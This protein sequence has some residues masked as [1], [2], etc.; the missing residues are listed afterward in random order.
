MSI[1]IAVQMSM[2]L[3]HS[4]DIFLTIYAKRPEITTQWRY[5]FFFQ[6]RP[7]KLLHLLVKKELMFQFANIQAYSR[8]I[9]S[10]KLLL[11]IDLVMIVR[12]YI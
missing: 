5:I 6:T 9:S 12:R 2:I 7:S 10:L 4:Q 1:D 11:D 8:S 3:F